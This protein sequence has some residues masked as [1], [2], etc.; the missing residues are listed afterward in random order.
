MQFKA[1][2]RL[3]GIKQ[4]AGEME[5]KKFSS[6]KFHLLVDITDNTAGGAIGQETR[7]FTFGDA[8]EYNKWSHLKDAFPEGGIAVD[9]VFDVA[10]ASDGKTKLT[11]ADIK[12]ASK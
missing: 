10:S 4:S 3:L 11:L 9:V 6:T 5:G 12:P 8:T 1:K 7:P 2:S